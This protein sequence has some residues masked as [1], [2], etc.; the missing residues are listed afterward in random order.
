MQ[1]RNTQHFLKVVLEAMSV[2]HDV[3]CNK[4]FGATKCFLRKGVFYNKTFAA[5]RRFLQQDV[6]CKKAFSATRRL[7]QKGVFCNKTFA[8]VMFYGLCCT[9]KQYMGI[10][11]I[12]FVVDVGGF[13]A[14][15]SSM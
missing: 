2:Q 15:F 8:A 14:L 1:A 13:E 11:P 7:L 9:V 12:H 6:C 10:R 5:K 3:C 4:I